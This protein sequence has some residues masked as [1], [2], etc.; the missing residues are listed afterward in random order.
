MEIE[1]LLDLIK[2]TIDDWQRDIDNV[3]NA[4]HSPL[5]EVETCEE[6]T[7]F[8]SRFVYFIFC[9]WISPGRSI[10]F[11]KGVYWRFCDEALREKYG[12]YWESVAFDMMRTGAEGGTYTLL[13]TL[14][15]NMAQIG[16]RNTIKSRISEYWEGMTAEK[17]KRDSRKYVERFGHLLPPTYRNDRSLLASEFA[18]VLEQHP[19]MVQRMRQSL[20][21]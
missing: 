5:P 16:A 3:I 18:R 13:K 4:Y 15:E 21:R 19:E 14:A 1:E 12:P 9:Q 2:N 20:R 17:L 11:H 7:M 10:S 8:L 6:T